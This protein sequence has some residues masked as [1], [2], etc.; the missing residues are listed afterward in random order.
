MSYKSPS[1]EFFEN[2]TQSIPVNTTGAGFATVGFSTGGPVNKLMAFTSLADFEKTMGG[3]V[4]NYELT[5]N[6]IYKAMNTGFGGTLYFMRI[7]EFS[8]VADGKASVG[9]SN[10][11][12]GSGV[13]AFVGAEY[14]NLPMLKPWFI[15]LDTEFTVS[16]PD[17]ITATLNFTL[18]TTTNITRTYTMNKLSVALVEGGSA[19]GIYAVSID[20][21]VRDLNSFATFS[22]IATAYATDVDGKNGLRIVSKK[23]GNDQTFTFNSFTVD[24]AVSYGVSANSLLVETTTGSSVGSYPTEGAFTFSIKAKYPGTYMNG[25]VVK[26]IHN[27]DSVSGTTTYTINVY[28]DSTESKLLESFSGL[29]LANIADIINDETYGSSFITI[30]GYSFNGSSAFKA[31]KYVLGKG[32]VL[33]DGTVY[34]IMNDETVL[35]SDG[36]PKDEMNPDFDDEE[37]I[38]KMFADAISNKEF[39][40]MDNVAFSVIATPDCGDQIVQDAGIE[41]ASERGDAMYIVDVPYDYTAL[42]KSGI[43][44]VVDWSNGKL[45]RSV[46]ITSS[47]AGI[48]YGWLT[49]TNAYG[50]NSL[51]C[52]PSVFVVPKILEVDEKYGV[53]YA[54]AG[55]VRGV[56][57]ASNYFY[58]PDSEDREL[59]CGDNNVNPIIFSN[60]RGL[61]I[62]SQKTGLRENS[63]R[64]RIHVRRMLND[65]KRK[66]YNALDVYRFEF[67]S[68]DIHSKASTTLDGILF[69]YK[70]AGA[71]ES[72]AVS[73][74]GGEGSDSDVMNVY[75]DVVPYGLVE[76]IRI[77]ISISEAGIVASE[78]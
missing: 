69:P 19:V 4:E 62:F 12:N 77:Y 38:I 7:G 9:V 56:I 53:Y 25:A 3:P 5:H 18:N 49:S 64:N 41:L 65:I 17:V 67:N 76:R 54:P 2:E 73:V 32:E 15:I 11:I 52:P 24:N 33:S 71:L 39:L 30:E 40:N 6:M 1:I 78:S 22:N 35:G 47:Y 20:K 58:S 8:E 51:I 29:T 37:K 26:C 13:D 14:N 59:L 31:G 23:I 46:A 44:K 72:Y 43:Q 34:E 66:T 55:S 16:K 27:V 74:N 36:V 21:I 75:L 42:K 50:S 63:P 48:F 61:M 68:P 45:D 57:N 60:T 70:N 10:Y 28:K